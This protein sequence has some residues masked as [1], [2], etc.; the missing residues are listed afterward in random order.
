MTRHFDILRFSICK[1]LR[2]RCFLEQRQAENLQ[3]FAQCSF[4]LQLLANDCHE[5]VYTD[6]DPHLR[7]HRVLARAVEPFNSQVLLDPL[8]EQFRLPAIMPPKRAGYIR[9]LRGTLPRSRPE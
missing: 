3:N 1:R 8:E 9:P 7:L 6:R 2:N 5:H 4:D